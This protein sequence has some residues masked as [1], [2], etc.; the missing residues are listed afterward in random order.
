MLD[1]A[2]VRLVKAMDNWEPATED[3]KPVRSSV[4][5][6]INFSE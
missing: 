4:K 6:P 2:A 1:N 3:G 5:L